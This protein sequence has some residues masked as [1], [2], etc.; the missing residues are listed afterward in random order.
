M[1]RIAEA[2][3]SD[4]GEIEEDDLRLICKFF[5]CHDVKVSLEIGTCKISPELSAEFCLLVE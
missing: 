4:D 2:T 1:S 3:Y 5:L